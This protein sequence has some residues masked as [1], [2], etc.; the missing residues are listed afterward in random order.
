MGDSS[1]QH[2]EHGRQ[3]GTGTPSESDSV[4]WMA[5]QTSASSFFS[6]TTTMFTIPYDPRVSYNLYN[7]PEN[8]LH[9]EGSVVTLN[10][11]LSFASSPISCAAHH[12]LSEHSNNV[13]SCCVCCCFLPLKSH[14]RSVCGREPHG[15]EKLHMTHFP[16]K[17]E[18]TKEEE[19][20]NRT[21][22]K[23]FICP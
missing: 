8:V 4:M 17:K 14:I 2:P 6:T 10:I 12:A 23:W 9:A 11:I 3:T 18:E 21:E 20:K 15:Y 22:K 16:L 19:K 5:T 7:R 1:F 13:P